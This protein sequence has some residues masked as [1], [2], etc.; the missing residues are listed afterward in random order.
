[1]TKIKIIE[2]SAIVCS[3]KIF[4]KLK[5]L[6]W[7]LLM[8]YDSNTFLFHLPGLSWLYLKFL[9]VQSCRDNFCCALYFL[10]ISEYPFSFSPIAGLKFW[11][12]PKDRGG[13]M[14]EWE[15]YFKFSYSQSFNL[16]IQ[17]TV[18]SSLI[19][20]NSV[21][22]PETIFGYLHIWFLES[23]WLEELQVRLEKCL[24]YWLKI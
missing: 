21:S 6:S 20:A 9:I 2:S 23:R 15:H 3:K 24:K 10:N 16:R 11:S 8:L 22:M 14:L 4:K 7:K 1:M 12:Y 18:T 5:L 19:N 13:T 17:T